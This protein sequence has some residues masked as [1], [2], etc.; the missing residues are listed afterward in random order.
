MS[1]TAA[2]NVIVEGKTG[3]D[4]TMA[5]VAM[6][7]LTEAYP[8]HPWHVEVRDGCLILKHMK[9][10]GKWAQVRRVGKVY[11]ASELKRAV[12]RLGGEFLERAGMRRGRVI[13]GEFKG[14]VEGIPQKDLVP[15]VIG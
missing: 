3:T 14:T 7:A 12:V 8:G 2:Y 4:D 15:Q 5:A 9:I 11:S 13:D 10:S 6:R 1:D